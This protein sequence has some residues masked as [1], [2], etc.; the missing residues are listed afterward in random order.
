MRV[1][2]EKFPFALSLC[3]NFFNVT[4]PDDI[5]DGAKPALQE[6]GPFCYE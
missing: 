5:K 1:V 2:W 6:V 4:N 3:F